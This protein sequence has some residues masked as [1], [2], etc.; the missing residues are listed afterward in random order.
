MTLLR[1][2]RPVAIAILFVISLSQAD[3]PIVP[4]ANAFQLPD[5]HEQDRLAIRTAARDYLLALQSGDRQRVAAAW[6]P[7]GV[8]IDAAGHT[9]S[10]R[11][12]AKRMPVVSRD[13]PASPLSTDRSADARWN[14]HRTPHESVIRF[15]TPDVA[16]EDGQ[17]TEMAG[18]LTQDAIGRYTAVWVRRDQQWLLDSVRESQRL[19][20]APQDF[21]RGL[22][23]MLGQWSN[24]ASDSAGLQVSITSRWSLDQNYLLRE[25]ELRLPDSTPLAVTQRIGW[26]ARRRQLRAWTFDSWGGH[27]EAVVTFQGQ[28]LLFT[29][30]GTTVDGDEVLSRNSYTLNSDGSV[31]WESQSATRDGRRFPNQKLRLVRRSTSSINPASESTPR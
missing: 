7:E 15:P 29:G 24:D 22:T 27:S 28:Q 31:T 17:S 8:F 21:L 25:V 26:D 16:I 4:R 3:M 5:E 10:G 20:T 2:G 12:L 19:K 9:T 6:T 11:E 30:T 23:W 13:Q 18:D 14:Q 1:F